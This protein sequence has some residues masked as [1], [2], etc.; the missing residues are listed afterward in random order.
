MTDAIRRALIEGDWRA[1]VSLTPHLPAPPSDH[2]AEAALH[3][4]RTQARSVPMRLRAWSHR[5]LCERG[6][7]SGLPD[8]LRPRAER[9]Y[10]TVVEAVGISCNAVS[11]SM[12]PIVSE[13]RRSMEA[14]VLDVYADTKHRGHPDPALVRGRMREARERTVKKLLGI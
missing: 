6:Y 7:P 5:W 1:L 2:A 10:P 3:H 13:I 4:A 12:R 14:V 8:I 11:P 9:L